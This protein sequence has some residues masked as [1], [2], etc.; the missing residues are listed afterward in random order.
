[1]LIITP[2]VTHHTEPTVGVTGV[3][4]G[5][6]VPFLKHKTSR[7]GLIPLVGY[8][9]GHVPLVE[10]EQSRVELE[11]KYFCKIS[12]NVLFRQTEIWPVRHIFFFKTQNS[13][14]FAFVFYIFIPIISVTLKKQ[15]HYFHM[16]STI[17]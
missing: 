10:E 17:L 16:L 8:G 9:R 15:L 11:Q 12:E 1:M 13:S 14:I 4:G 6:V 3:R 2:A 7:D 5:G